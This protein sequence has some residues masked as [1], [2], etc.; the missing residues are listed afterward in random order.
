MSTFVI[1]VFPSKKD[2]LFEDGEGPKGKAEFVT[3]IDS[4]L[5]RT[6]TLTIEGLEY[7]VHELGKCVA[8]TVTLEKGEKEEWKQKDLS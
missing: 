4:L 8:D 1:L 7:R 3:G 2:R 5:H 6:H